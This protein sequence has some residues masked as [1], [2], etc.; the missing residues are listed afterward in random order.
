MDE[1][2]PRDILG[3][4]ITLSDLKW[5]IRHLMQF[6]HCS[7]IARLL[8]HNTTYAAERERERERERDVIGGEHNYSID[9]SFTSYVTDGSVMGMDTMDIRTCSLRT[10]RW[11]NQ[12][13]LLLSRLLE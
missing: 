9:T 10:H 7:R 11:A 2:L 8:V 4:K 6:I 13:L 1:G 5:S 3:D 12:P